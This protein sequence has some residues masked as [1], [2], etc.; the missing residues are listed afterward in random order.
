MPH[1]GV[2]P[3]QPQPA[4]LVPRRAGDRGGLGRLA[5]GDDDRLGGHPGRLE[6]LDGGARGRGERR[7][8]DHGGLRRPASTSESLGLRA[9]P[10]DDLVGRGTGDG[11]AAHGATG[12]VGSAAGTS[13]TTSSGSRLPV[14]TVIVATSP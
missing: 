8:V 7:G 13:A 1:D 6:R 14:K 4:E 2:G 9:R 5:V 10:D 12:R 3:G 11:H